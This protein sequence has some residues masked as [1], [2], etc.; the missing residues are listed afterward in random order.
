MQHRS[1]VGHAL[2]VAEVVAAALNLLRVCDI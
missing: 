2:Y 1:R